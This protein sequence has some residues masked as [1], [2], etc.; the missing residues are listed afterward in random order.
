MNL[1]ETSDHLTNF[2]TF[3]LQTGGFIPSKTLSVFAFLSFVWAMNLV[4]Q[5]VYSG[6]LIASLAVNKYNLPVNDLKELAE[7]T[8]HKVGV[9]GGSIHEYI[10][11]VI[12]GLQHAA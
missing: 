5:S 6:N 12:S 10:F 2:S 4:I 11:K 1:P 8:S 9:L 7:Q 3:C